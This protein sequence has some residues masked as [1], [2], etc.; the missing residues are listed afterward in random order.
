MTTIDVPRTA[1]S[2]ATRPAPLEIAPE[3]FVIQADNSGGGS[4][5]V[6]QMNSMVIRGAE[7]VVVDTGAPVHREQY[8]ADLFAIVEPE[9][10]RWVFLSHDDPD[11]YGNVET[12]MAACPNATLVSSWFICDRL[13]MSGLSVPPTRW[14]WLDDGQ[15]LDVG[16]RQVVAVR[17]PLYDQP[18]TRGLFDPSTGVYWAGDAFAV[19]L[20]RTMGWITELTEDGDD[21][22]SEGFTLFQQWNSPWSTIVDRDRFG[23]EVDRVERLGISTIATCHGPAVPESHVAAAFDLMRAVPDGQAPPQPGQPVLDDII[24]AIL[25]S[26]P[27][28]LQG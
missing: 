27:P 9:D 7:P 20:P 19:P 4:P 2:P 24:D 22:W 3:T 10:V 21:A 8:L 13:A 16:D 17:P 25:A 18:T 23:A 14:R 28:P 1:H 26:G 5:V 12:V 6:V 11:H 15:R